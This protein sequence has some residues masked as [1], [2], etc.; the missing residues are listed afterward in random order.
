MGDQR[1][2]PRATL[3]REQLQEAKMGHEEDAHQGTFAE[4]QSEEEHH[5]EREDRRDFAEGVEERP[6]HRHEGTFAEGQAEEEYHPE[7]EEPG[8][9]AEGVERPD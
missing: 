6:E 1:G 7:R 5:P 3:I 4:G 9:F 2:A 8:D